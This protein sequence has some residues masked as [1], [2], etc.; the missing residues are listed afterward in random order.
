VTPPRE[1]GKASLQLSHWR[2]S[3]AVSGVAKAR[4]CGGLDTR[5]W[6]RRDRMRMPKP[7]TDVAVNG[8]T[9]LKN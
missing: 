7:D 9:C 4:Q 5:K 2:R 1:A 8:G 6:I 3:A